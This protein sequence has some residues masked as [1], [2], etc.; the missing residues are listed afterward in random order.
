RGP[1]GI[2]L[3]VGDGMG[4]AHFTLAR[5]LRGDEYRIGTMPEIGLVATD[6]ADNLVTDSAAAATA[7]ATGVKTNKG[8]IGTDPSGAP[9]RTVLELADARGLATG[10]VTT[11]VFVDATP[12]AF[13]AH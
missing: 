12:A 8:Y 4:S 3:V 11:A 9:A 6:A 13:A 7:F 5:Q 1:R 2:V 10:L